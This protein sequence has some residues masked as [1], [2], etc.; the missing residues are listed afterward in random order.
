MPPRLLHSFMDLIPEFLRSKYDHVEFIDKGAYGRIYKCTR[1]EITSAV[2]ALD[3]LDSESLER[4]KGEIAILKRIDHK[5]VVNIL[6]VGEDKG[7][8]WYESEYADQGHLGKMASYLFY[9]DLDR[10]NYFR[11]ICLGVQALHE[12]YP[13]IIHRD[14]KPSNILVFD[15]PDGGR[16][17]LLKIADFGLAAIVGESRGITRTGTVIGTAH[18][19]APEREKNPRIKTPQSDIYS[20]GITF[21]EACTGR[22]RL[23]PENL[24]LV[25]ELLRPI[26]EKM[27]REH[28]NDRYKNVV[29]VIQAL[30]DLP[31]DR[32]F[33]GRELGENEWFVHTY[34]INIGRELENALELLHKCDEGNVLARLAALELTLDRLVDACDH[35][36][37]ILMNIGRDIAALI[38]KAS[39]EALLHV[40]RRF[41]NAARFTTDQDFFRPSQS[42][43]HFLAN[44]FDV[45]SYRPTKS[46]C[47]EGLAY[48][49]VRFGN[50]EIKGCLYRTIKS[51]EDPSYMEE[52]ALCL[53]QVG[54]EDIANLLDGSLD[55]R[56][57]DLEAVWRALKN[58]E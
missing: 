31:F 8:Y 17:S 52:L 49:L 23:S 27:I 55:R 44:T 39:P 30:N 7:H 6:N 19:I 56:N 21:L 14:L 40:V 1:A 2:K 15:N 47:L 57:I 18:Y 45:S 43:F 12:F 34:H 42:W 29:E 24:N 16:D 4:F 54:R 41:D 22:S 13:P 9:S 33:Y 58:E 20:I 53:H 36:A 32:L 10:V 38:E 26:I 37:S 28:P 51:I 35:E 3:A 5:N 25:P 46:L 50:P 11:Q 48:F